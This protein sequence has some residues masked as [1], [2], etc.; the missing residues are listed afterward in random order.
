MVCER[1]MITI[2]EQTTSEREQ[3][4]RELFESIRPYLDKGYN[5]RRALILIGRIS[6]NTKLNN[7]NGWFRDLTQYGASRG[8]DY[9]DFRFNRTDRVG[10]K[11]YRGYDWIHFGRNIL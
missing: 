6:E 9:Y 1:I 11:P 4:T 10:C 3:E 5:Y 2:I 8:Y 7:R